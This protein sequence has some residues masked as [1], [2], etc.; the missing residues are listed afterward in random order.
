MTQLAEMMGFQKYITSQEFLKQTRKRAS[1]LKLLD[2]ITYAAI[3]VFKYLI[4]PEKNSIQYLNQTKLDIVI[5]K[6]S[7]S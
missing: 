2:S 4:Q 5:S 7:I 1:P 3:E 6:L